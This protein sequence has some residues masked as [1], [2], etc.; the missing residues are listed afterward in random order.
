M[1]A[2][3][4]EDLTDQVIIVTG[5]NS[6]LGLET[7]VALAAMG[8]TVV[9]TARSQAKGE[10][11]R[12]EVI[13][14]S[15]RDRVVL[16]MLDLGSFESIRAF[17]AWFLDEYD[18]LD[19]LVNNAGGMVNNR[20]ETSDGF[21]LMF[22]VNHLGHFLLT[23]LLR[24]RLVASAPSRVVVLSSF[25]HRMAVTGLDRTDLQSEREFRSFPT[26]GRSKLANAQFT[27]ELAHQLEGTGVTVNCVHPGSIRS[28]FAGDGDTGTMGWLIATFG[29]F[30]MRSPKGGAKT[31]VLMASSTKP[32]IVGATGG[33]WSHGRRWPASKHGRSREEARW[34]WEESARLVAE[35]P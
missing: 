21:E 22:G 18:R 30:V 32:R 14:R 5:A 4:R 15:G 33:Y 23:D 20:Q 3:Q 10:A 11:A 31:Q 16:G 2:T 9:M 29:R 26:Y 28:G 35:V 1:G 6:G 12:A 24:E 27:L 25:A 17:A 13:E 34:L 7:A 8:A 19:V